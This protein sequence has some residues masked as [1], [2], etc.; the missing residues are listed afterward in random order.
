[1]RIKAVIVELSLWEQIRLSN[2][3]FTDNKLDYY[4]FSVLIVFELS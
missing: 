1:M 3:C 2:T 4:Y